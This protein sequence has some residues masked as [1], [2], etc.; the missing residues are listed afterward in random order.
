MD[1]N[2]L[3]DSEF[4]EFTYDLLGSLGFTNLSWRRGSGKGGAT[5]DQGRDVVGQRLERDV[6]RHER[7]ETWFVQCKRYESGVPPEK[8]QGAIAW[9]TSER[10]AVLLFVASNF[11]SNPAKT[12][13]TNYEASNR[14]PFRI[15]VWERKDLENFVVTQPHLAKKYRIDIGIPLQAVHPAH[16]L[17]ALRPSMNSLDYFFNALGHIDP[18]MRDDLLSFAFLSII[19]PRFREAQTGK[20]T[21]AQLRIDPFDYATFRDRCYELKQKSRLGEG[22]LVQAIVNHTLAWGREFADPAEVD[23]LRRRHHNTIAYL[24]EQLP[25]VAAEKK[26]TYEKV[27]RLSRITIDSAPARQ[28]E[29]ERSYRLFCE[30]VLP[31]LHLEEHQIT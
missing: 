29:A 9:A 20:E 7:L 16:L 18:Q 23:N 17:Y 4:E 28:Q 11:L 12:W 8:L 19:N 5:A 13:L 10:P 22:F 30:S 21:L 3:S 24:T 26:E 25:S 15:K 1:F 31:L 14:P 6:D 2:H 27:I